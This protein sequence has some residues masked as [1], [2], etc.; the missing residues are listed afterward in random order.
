MSI[1]NTFGPDLISKEL[2]MYL[3]WPIRQKS[4]LNFRSYL[5]KFSFIHLN[6]NLRIKQLS[7]LLFIGKIYYIPELNAPVYWLKHSLLYHCAWND[8]VIPLPSLSHQ[9]LSLSLPP[10][11]WNIFFHQAVVPQK[12]QI[13]SFW[14]KNASIYL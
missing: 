10:Y 4:L 12:S 7:Y 9:S 14:G 3:I 8:Y 2:P 13:L 1:K 6:N 5:F 11:I